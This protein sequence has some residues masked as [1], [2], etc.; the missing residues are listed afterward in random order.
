MSS[1]TVDKVEKNNSKITYHYSIIGP[2]KKYFNRRR[3]YTIDYY[4]N[5]EE[6]PESI[7]IIPFLTNI[8]PVT[9]I[10]D[11][12]IKL[13]EIDKDFYE[14][15]EKFKDGYIKMY[16]TLEFKGTIEYKKLINNKYDK[17]E[18]SGAFFSGGVDALSTLIS[19]IDEQPLLVT[20]WG[21]DIKLEDEDAW[22]TVKNKIMKIAEEFHLENKFIKTEFRYIFHEKLLDFYVQPKSKDKWWHGFQHGIAIIGHAAPIA[23]K[24]N[25]KQM[26][27]AASFTPEFHSTCASDPTIDNYVKLSKTSVHHDGYD[28]SRNEKIL[29]VCDYCENNNRKVEFRVCLG[30][31]GDKNCCRCEKCYRTIVEI[32][33]EGKD[34]NNYGFAI[35]EETFKCMEYDMKNRILLGHTKNWERI[36]KHLNEKKEIFEND[37]RLNWIYDYDFSKVNKPFRKK[38]Y[39][40]Y[41]AIRKRVRKY[42]LRI[43]E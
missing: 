13:N 30:S 36:Q 31:K 5:I 9:W 29:N 39:R 2:V 34:P 18:K 25:L 15:I 14:S 6:V 38:V 42:I 26:H 37:E 17:Q 7:A 11:T 32:I 27:I 40:V 35:N 33:I 28:M 21:S 41:F 16:P 1:I 19:N 20:L 23:Y 10:F 3:K 8:L 24:Y 4:E 12:T 43:N 22:N